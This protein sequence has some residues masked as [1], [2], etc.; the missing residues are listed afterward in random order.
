MKKSVFEAAVLCAT[1]LSLTSLCGA[2]EVAALKVTILSTMLADQG[3]GE[4]GFF[5]TPRN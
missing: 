3:I 5:K 2:H 4:W 1:L